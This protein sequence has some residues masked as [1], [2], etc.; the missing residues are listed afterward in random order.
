M[1]LKFRTMHVDAEARLTEMLA[2]N[3]ELKLEYDRHTSCAAIPG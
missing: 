1:A 2:G 3:A